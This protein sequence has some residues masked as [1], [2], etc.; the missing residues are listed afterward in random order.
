MKQVIIFYKKRVLLTAAI[1]LPVIALN[2]QDKDEVA[3]GVKK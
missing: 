3:A 1:F 2:A